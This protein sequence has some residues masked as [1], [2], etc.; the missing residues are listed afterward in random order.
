MAA[1]Q[2]A[3]RSLGR[4]DEPRLLPLPAQTRSDED[5]ARKIPVCTPGLTSSSSCLD[6]AGCLDL[7]HSACVT[8]CQGHGVLGVEPVNT[9]AAGDV[10]W[11]SLHCES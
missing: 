7:T 1:G 4:R 8:L 6:G 3:E 10:L 2:G 11:F 9:E 5:R